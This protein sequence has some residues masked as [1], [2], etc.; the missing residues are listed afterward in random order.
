[1]NDYECNCLPNYYHPLPAHDP[2]NLKLCYN[3]V[4]L[5]LSSEIVIELPRNSDFSKVIDAPAWIPVAF[6]PAL[7]TGWPSLVVSK[8]GAV[9]L[10]LRNTLEAN[11]VLPFP[12][13]GIPHIERDVAAIFAFF[14][15]LKESPAKN[16]SRVIYSVI[17]DVTSPVFKA[18]ASD[19]Q[20]SLP[21]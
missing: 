3:G 2:V 12:G 1:M 16:N 14:T 9:F 6:N 21:S 19:F 4:F 18:I 13:A 11:P 5:D 7:E 15:K 17:T 8:H 10:V 20:N